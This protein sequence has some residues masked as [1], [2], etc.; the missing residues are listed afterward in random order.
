MHVYFGELE[1]VKSS[2]RPAAR[3]PGKH[4]CSGTAHQ[5]LVFK[6]GKCYFN[7]IFGDNTQS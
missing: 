2:A 5:I 6:Q 3:P 7:Q 4:G 1:S